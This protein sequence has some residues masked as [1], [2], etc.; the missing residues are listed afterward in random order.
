M[1]AYKKILLDA[2][3]GEDWELIEVDDYSHDWWCDEHW[4]IRSVRESW[5]IEVMIFFLVDPQTD[6]PRKKGEGIWAITATD[7]FPETWG[8][9]SRG[10]AILPLSKRKFDQKLERFLSSLNQYRRSISR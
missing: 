8:G 6:F 1:T 5:G 7:K 3:T 10:I 4:L 9:A 2:L